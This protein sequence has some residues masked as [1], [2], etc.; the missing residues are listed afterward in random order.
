MRWRLLVLVILLASSIPLCLQPTEEKPGGGESQPATTLYNVTL[1]SSYFEKL[2]GIIEGDTTPKE[3]ERAILEMAQVAV[4]LNDSERVI[5]Y[6]KEVASTSKDQNVV[7]A[8]YAAIDMIRDYYPPEAMGELVVD[9]EG[10]FKPGSTVN[11]TATVKAYSDCR[12]MVGIKRGVP[13]GMELKSEVRYKF[14]ISADGIE[15]FTFKVIPEQSGE[16]PMTIVLFLEKSRFDY[17]QIE[18]KIILRIDENG[19]EVVY[20]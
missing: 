17:Q 11:I 7:A 13:E 3:K 18:Q 4:M 6:L 2:K 5:E 14:E 8:A 12:G 15:M 19:G 1:D 20:Y 16:Y 9:V 10:D